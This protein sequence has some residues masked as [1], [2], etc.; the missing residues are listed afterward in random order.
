MDFLLI[1]FIVTS[2]TGFV[3]IYNKF[4]FV[5]QR[6][7]LS[8]NYILKNVISISISIF[9]ILLAVFLVRSFLF[10]P[11]RIP[12]GSMKPTLLEGDFIIVKKF[13][14]DI[15]IPILNTSVF[16]LSKPTHGDVIVFKHKKNV[17]M[18]KR[19]VAIPGNK[20]LYN[21]K[22]IY[23]N[24]M[25]QKQYDIGGTTDKNING[26]VLNVRYKKELLGNIKHDIYH[27]I[28][29]KNRKYKFNNIEIPKNSY[30]VLGD[31]RDNSQDS[32]VW[33]LVH[34][35]DI[36]GKAILIWMS[37][38]QNNKDIRWNRIGKKI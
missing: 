5:S 7:E 17:T 1:L 22:F 23:I 12:S 37:W 16:N 35:K 3:Y 20:I 33:G 34:K 2:L 25:I 13:N 10:E 27:I 32:R 9:P 28:G 21:N 19:V 4:F 6:Q 31:F 30:F 8:K 38:D 11:F 14:Y 36:L 29:L 24:N 18:I 26:L 15:N